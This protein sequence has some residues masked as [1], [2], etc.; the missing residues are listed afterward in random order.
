MAPRVPGHLTRFLRDA[1]LVEWHEAT[2]VSAP[3]DPDWCRV[4]HVVAQLEADTAISA[5]HAHTLGIDRTADVAAFLPVWTAEEAAHAAAIRA[6]LERQV[7]E[8]PTAAPGSIARRRRTVARLPR[9]A[10]GRLRPIGVLYG[11]LGAAA[12][13]VTVLVYGELATRV[14]D[15]AV[16]A[17]LREI[18]RQER[19]HCAFFR[20]LAR[21]RAGALSRVEAQLARRVLMAMW[22]PPGVPSLG[23]TVWRETFAPLLEDPRLRERVLG[24]DRVVDSVPGL[25][26]LGL[27]ERFLTDRQ[28]TGTRSTQDGS[29]WKK[30]RR[31]ASTFSNALAPVP[32]ETLSRSR[33]M[34]NDWIASSRSPAERVRPSPFGS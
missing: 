22:E 34:R 11:V 27:M 24:M 15:P 8:A 20:G 18:A 33:K 21:Q 6:V 3:V 13:Y 12:E 2:V 19:R 29:P 32:A 5:Q 7:Y 1:G 9:R 4:L 30:P 31:K 26:D 23:L 14:E 25:E 28:V 16:V 17:L 10:I